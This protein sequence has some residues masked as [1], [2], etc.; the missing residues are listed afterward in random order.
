VRPAAAALLSLSAVLLAGRARALD[1]ARPIAE[2][3]RDVWR[4]EQGLPRDTVTAMAQ[5]NDG[6]LWIGSALGLARFDGVRF[7]V[8]SSA[9]V[10]AFLHNYVR[11]LLV[12]ADGSLW[13][14][15]EHGLIRSR[16]GEFRAY[17]M[18]DGMSAHNIWKM[19]LAPDGALWI[20]SYGGGVMRFKDGVFRAFRV[21]DGLPSDR[22]LSVAADRQGSIWVATDG[23]GLSRIVGDRV[24]P[25][26]EE[27][28]FPGDTVESLLVDREGAL[29]AGSL[30]EA[31]ITRILDGRIVESHALAGGAP[32]RIPALLEDRD[33][34]IWAGVFGHGVARLFQGRVA[35]FSVS[36][37]LSSSLA[38][39]LFEDREGSIWIGTY[40]G[41][42]T[43]VRD[44]RVSVLARG[45]Y[46]RTVTGSAAGE[47]WIG[48]YGDGVSQISAA[49]LVGL[50]GL[51]SPSVRALLYDTDGSLWIG[52]DGSG[53]AHTSP[54]SAG[55]IKL[56]GQRDGLPSGTVNAFCRD[57]RGLWIATHGGLVLLD[58]EGRL[59][60]YTTRDGLSNDR[61][62]ALL[63]SRD[64]GLW[65]G[66]YNSGLNKLED[67]VFRTYKTSFEGISSLVEDAD[68]TLWIGTYAGGLDR[69]KDGVLSSITRKQ[70]LPSDTIYQVLTDADG[71]LWLGCGAGIARVARADAEA[72][73]DGR[74]AS[75]TALTLGTDDGLLTHECSGGT[76][77]AGWKAPDGRL[78]FG[79]SRGLAIV[80]PRHLPTNP[81]R[82]P[83]VV[84]EVVSG[85]SWFTNVARAE[86]PSGKELEIRYTAL[87]HA[88]PQ[89]VSFRYRL[90]GFD[91][92]WID[93]KGRRTAYYTNVPHGRYTF[94]V[95]AANNDGVWNR[96][97]ASVEIVV[98]RRAYETPRFYALVV[99]GVAGVG[100]LGHRLRVGRL[101]AR[102]R[103][104]EA[105]VE[106]RTR[107]L[108]EANRAKSAFLASMSHELRT[109]LNAVLGFAQLLG[110]D[111]TLGPEGRR[112][113]GIIHTS[114]EHLLGLIDDVLS[115]AKIESGKVA[116]NDE[117]FELGATLEGVV[118]MLRARAEAKG[119]SLSLEAG[120]LP[121]AVR[122]DEARLRQILLNLLGNAVKFTEQGSVR[123]AASWRDGTARFEVDDTG[124]GIPL[125]EQEALF[126]PFSQTT[127]GQRAKE[128]TGLGL[129]LSR[130]YARLMGG[131]ITLQS[132]AGR[133]CVF[134]VTA[135]LP[136]AAPVARETR[137]KA[138]RVAGLAPGFAPCRALVADDTPESLLLLT[139]LLRAVG[140]E[141][142][143][144]ADGREAV[145][146]WDAFAPRAVFMDMRM[147]VLDG[148]AATREIRGRERKS[149][150]PRCAI[151]AQSASA[152]DHE[153]SEYLAAGCDDF[154]PK[155]YREADVFDSL[156]RVAGLRFSYEDA[157]AVGTGS[158]PAGEPSVGRSRSLAG[159]PEPPALPAE[160]RD[161]LRRV[162]LV[163]GDQE[164][165]L[166]LAARV[167]ALDA[168]FGGR[169]EARI[170]AVDLDAVE[171]MLR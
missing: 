109:P 141:V 132:E 167:S 107:S 140:F 159:E 145:E 129:A 81:V 15:T 171:E 6:Y 135:A 34:A 117:D 113:L 43:R 7:T 152:L 112:Q 16:D 92:H 49:G 13:I 89:A 25:L 110:R 42:L 60:V 65:V 14:G 149:G 3:V 131:D 69:L 71:D 114:G 83:V 91:D 58:R 100:F 18:A 82:P 32:A 103:D 48:T 93:P 151:V 45:A 155:P 38:Q 168:A 104:L 61:V 54:S 143:E 56:L 122:G 79:T 146:Q 163:E 124:P 5:T 35:R 74:R 148:L 130:S 72:V 4:T 41:G 144:A 76:Q 106:E 28:R 126:R 99:F 9:N 20:A 51:P 10:P 11:G 86:L 170:R 62:S 22:I 19:A 8:F 136:A 162:L 105:L 63:P 127:T 40:S 70:G 139:S 78:Y 125:D 98:P 161:Q 96:E 164:T 17:S 95:I 119:L 160:L 128:G 142:A 73:A 101:E 138:R 165:A 67:G 84:E 77:P 134:T 2:F 75:L 59:R 53:V 133:G 21:K 55:R 169:L 137:V 27:L 118:G 153:S 111:A 123:L 47:V 39:V 88:A 26:P 52:T 102:K 36:D 120:G 68:G 50:A 33:G 12:T 115:I 29:W 90:E 154:L 85:T 66:T 156:A 147:P 80:N 121:A 31:R 158:P 30:R 97:G 1:P 87:S 108:A 23:G 64:G 116:R 44:G 166:R 94:R 150:R 57:P 46:V 37:G 157:G 24:E